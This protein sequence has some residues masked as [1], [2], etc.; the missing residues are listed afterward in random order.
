MYI[1]RRA[2]LLNLLIYLFALICLAEQKT[3]KLPKGFVYVDEIIPE[4]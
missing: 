3:E 2:V 1:V 4:I